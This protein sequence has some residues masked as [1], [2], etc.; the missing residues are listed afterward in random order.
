MSRKL[1][2][3]VPADLYAVLICQAGETSLS[4]MIVTALREIVQ[5]RRPL[6]QLETAERLWAN[7]RS[8]NKN[9]DN[10]LQD[11]LHE[12]FPS[13]DP[14]SAGLYASNGQ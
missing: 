6:L 4:K 11:V 5:G 13:T 7:C 14:E 8:Q 3:R 2:I 10:F 12:Q 1:S 9:P